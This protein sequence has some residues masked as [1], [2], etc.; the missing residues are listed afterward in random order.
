MIGGQEMGRSWLA[1]K[2]VVITRPASQSPELCERLIALGAVPVEFPVITIVSP[3]PG[4]TLDAAIARLSRFDW[5]I[6]TSVNGVKHFFARMAAAAR[7]GRTKAS[8]AGRRNTLGCDR[9]GDR[10]GAGRAR[11]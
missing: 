11:R 10:G 9:S 6:F 8:A 5:V 3:E 1:G 2:R 7:P 4:G